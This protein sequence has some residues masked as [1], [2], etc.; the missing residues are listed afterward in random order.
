MFLM[1]CFHK[2]FQNGTPSKRAL[3]REAIESP[4]F[5]KKRK[6]LSM[7]DSVTSVSRLVYSLQTCLFYW[8]N[9]AKVDNSLDKTNS[10]YFTYLQGKRRINK[11]NPFGY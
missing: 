10:K 3:G 2:L 9:D 11:E 5:L 7:D 1:V 8:L 4:T 6:Q